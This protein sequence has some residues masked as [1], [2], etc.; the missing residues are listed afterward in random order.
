MALDA[1]EF[2]RLYEESLRDPEGFWSR[3]AGR[4]DWMRRPAQV[5]EW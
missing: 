3:A 4:L 5:K 1:A 2:T